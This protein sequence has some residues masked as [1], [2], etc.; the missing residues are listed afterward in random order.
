VKECEAEAQAYRALVGARK[1]TVADSMERFFT[2]MRAAD[3]SRAESRAAY[4][5]LLGS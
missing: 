5:K 3:D 4:R 1:E 2:L